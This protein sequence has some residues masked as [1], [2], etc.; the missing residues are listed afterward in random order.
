[1][2]DYF[3]IST[4][5]FTRIRGDGACAVTW[6]IVS[7]RFKYENELFLCAVWSLNDILVMSGGMLYV[8]T[9]FNFSFSYF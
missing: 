1:M 5:V 9:L 6:E 4:P 2:F 8:S 7:A 3:S